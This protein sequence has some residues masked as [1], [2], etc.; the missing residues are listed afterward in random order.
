VQSPKPVGLQTQHLKCSPGKYGACVQKKEGNEGWART[1]PF[2]YIA[3]QVEGTQ[4]SAALAMESFF[5]NSQSDIYFMFKSKAAVQ[6]IQQADN[7]KGGKLTEALLGNPS[8][9]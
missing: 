4:H 8:L 1:G 3:R 5:W 6:S 2:S 9:K 7:N